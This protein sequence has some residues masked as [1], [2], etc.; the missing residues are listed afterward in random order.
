MTLCY[1]LFVLFFCVCARQREKGHGDGEVVVAQVR[2]QIDHE[3]DTRGGACDRVI[4]SGVPARGKRV[5]VER[6]LVSKGCFFF[7]APFSRRR[8]W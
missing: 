3:G 7:P 8:R 2:T 1:Y 6:G 5:F 4:K